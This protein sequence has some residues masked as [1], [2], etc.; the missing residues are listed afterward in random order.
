MPGRARSR[1]LDA[2]LRKPGSFRL[3]GSAFLGDLCA[4][5]CGTVR[6][7]PTANL[8]AQ[9]R[10]KLGRTPEAVPAAFGCGAGTRGGAATAARYSALFE[11]CGVG[12]SNC[13]PALQRVHLAG[14]PVRGRD[15]L[16][17]GPYRAPAQGEVCGAPT[18][19]LRALRPR[20]AMPIRHTPVRFTSCDTAPSLAHATAQ[21]RTSRGSCRPAC[22][23][24]TAL[25]AC[26]GGFV[27]MASPVAV[28]FRPGVCPKPVR[29]AWECRNSGGFRRQSWRRAGSAACG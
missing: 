12:R 11:S 17:H 29:M 18:G 27:P 25:P 4:T 5:W 8:G 10:G 26:Y 6:A 7:I 13:R 1:L 23:S 16:P 15:R 20:E 22:L 3:G 9:L 28:S 19:E 21:A 24:G 2:I 14:R